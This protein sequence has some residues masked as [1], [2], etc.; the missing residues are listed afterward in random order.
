[1]AVTVPVFIYFYPARDEVQRLEVAHSVSSNVK[2]QSLLKHF[3]IKSRSKF[4]AF[5][6]GKIIVRRKDG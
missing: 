6:A 2:K 5:E 3:K 4:V 1:M